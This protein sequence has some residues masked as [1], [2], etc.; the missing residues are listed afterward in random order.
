MLRLGEDR[1]ENEPLRREMGRRLLSTV[2]LMD[3]MISPP[4]DFPL[5][6]PLSEP[7]SHPCGEDELLRM[8]TLQPIPLQDVSSANLT[9]ELLKLSKHFCQVFMHHRQGSTLQEWEGLE[10]EQKTWLS[11]LHELLVYTPINFERHRAKNTLREFIYLHLLHHHVC[12]LIYFSSLQDSD[13]DSTPGLNKTRIQNCYQHATE[14]TEIAQHT[15]KAAGFDLHNVVFGQM[16]A[17]SAAVHMHAS[18]TAGSKEQKEVSQMRV[19]FITDCLSRISGH[20]RMFS[21]IVSVGK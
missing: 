12:Q 20:S 10:R 11:S 7:F 6:F 9:D 13:S 14:I 2:I 8:K 21:R 4:L 1:G 15:L 18:L 3:R 5:Y 19:G 17:V 16:L